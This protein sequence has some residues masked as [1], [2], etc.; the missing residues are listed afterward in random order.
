MLDLFE[1]MGRI[2]DLDLPVCIL[3]ASGTGKE[4]VA[5]TLHEEGPRRGHPF[6]PVHCG[7][8]P[9]ALVE[10][11]MFGHARGSFTGAVSDRKGLVEEADG[12][13]LFLDEVGEL[14]PAAQ[15]KLLRFL[16]DGEVR[17]IGQRRPRNLDVRVL[18]ATHRDLERETREGR[19]REDLFYRL[20]VVA[21]HVPPLR[22]R[23]ADI[24][25]LADLFLGRACEA[26]GRHAKAFTPGARARL[27][28]HPWRGNVRELQNAVQ[29][30]MASSGPSRLVRSRDLPLRPPEP[31]PK[32]DLRSLV[33]RF[34]RE[35]IES[36]L[37]LEAGSRSRTARRLGICR[38]TLHNKMR[39][40]GLVDS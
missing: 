22:K 9:D 6:V 17:R 5:R 23:S 40:Y 35:A 33:E 37:E 27:A 14:P 24:Q 29:A 7:A 8:L 30:A 32:Q 25:G 36:A 38:Q 11:E 12:G 20:H 39:K 2:L 26:N 10:A 16:Q 21:L 13:T 18:A 28:S 4:L 15:A 3:G 31:D 1:R 19:F 34:E